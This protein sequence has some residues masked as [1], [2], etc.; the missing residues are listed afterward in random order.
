MPRSSIQLTPDVKYTIAPAGGAGSAQSAI[1]T[2]GPRGIG[3]LTPETEYWSLTPDFMNA[4]RRA[5]NGSRMVLQGEMLA[6]PL[7]G[8]PVAG[9]YPTFTMPAFAAW[10]ATTAPLDSVLWLGQGMNNSTV[11][12]DFK[13]LVPPT[14]STE[15]WRGS[16]TWYVTTTSGEAP[17]EPVIGPDTTILTYSTVTRSGAAASWFSVRLAPAQVPAK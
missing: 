8:F 3:T 15:P 1:A 10:T 12:I 9:A 17:V 5:V 7:D 2:T 6:L 4:V 11:G 16:M 14:S 13:Y